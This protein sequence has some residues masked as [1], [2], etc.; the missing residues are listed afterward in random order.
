MTTDS[1]PLTDDEFEAFLKAN[2]R[3]TAMN[4]ILDHMDR[5]SEARRQKVSLRK[6]AEFLTTASG[7]KIDP[8]TLSKVLS[9]PDDSES[10]ANEMNLLLLKRRNRDLI[11]SRV[12]AGDRISK[13]ELQ[14]LATEPGSMLPSRIERRVAT[15][16]AVA[17]VKPEQV[18]DA[19]EPSGSTP[20]SVAVKIQGN[21]KV[22]L[23]DVIKQSEAA[24]K[25]RSIPK[26][27]TFRD[28]SQDQSL[29]P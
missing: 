18:I 13:A 12:Q 6:I 26:P 1:K 29:Q 23:S 9:R 20:S 14:E 21:G 27:L 5:V 17:S 2:A 10:L 24:A 16:E 11:R 3:N 8:A 15:P 28:R 4:V 22:D 25:Q 7:I 19:S